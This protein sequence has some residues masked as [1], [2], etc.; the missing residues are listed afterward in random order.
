M[1]T[2][3]AFDSNALDERQEGIECKLIILLHGYG[4]CGSDLLS[5]APYMLEEVRGCYWYAPNAIQP[6]PSFGYQWF[7]YEGLD[8]LS[9]NMAEAR[10]AIASLLNKKIKDLG[11]TTEQ[12]CLIGFSQGGMVA[13]DLAL[14]SPEPFCCLVSFSGALI[15]SEPT[16]PYQTPLCLIHGKED[17][18]VPFSEMQ[19]SASKLTSW[20]YPVACHAIDGLG[21]S[22]DMRGIQFA[23]AFILSCLEQKQT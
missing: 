20:D 13:L 6:R 8:L 9:K 10:P 22:I 23:K 3:T 17:G 7:D 21:H 12:V 16:A 5:I 2:T 1:T 18:V 15:S 14:S 4:S 11:L 19:R